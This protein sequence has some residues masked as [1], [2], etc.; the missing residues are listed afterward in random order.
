MD[1]LKPV[2]RTVDSITTA[3]M[4][5]DPTP[6]SVDESPSSSATTPAACGIYA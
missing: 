6:L 1:E 2:S 4:T 3:S 5:R